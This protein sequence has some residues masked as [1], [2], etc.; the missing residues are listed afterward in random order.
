MQSLP[1]KDIVSNQDT[2]YVF[3]HSHTT[4]LASRKIVC[5]SMPSMAAAST[6]LLIFAAHLSLMACSEPPLADTISNNS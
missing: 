2:A 4:S 5:S 1:H 3:A 6:F